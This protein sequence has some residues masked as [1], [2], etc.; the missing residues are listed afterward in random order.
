VFYCEA[1]AANVNTQKTWTAPDSRIKNVSYPNV[2][3]SLRA[4]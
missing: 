3:I 1:A 4:L 2:R